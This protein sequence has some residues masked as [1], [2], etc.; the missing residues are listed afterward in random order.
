MITFAGRVV[1]L[2][3]I[4]GHLRD[5]HVMWRQVQEVAGLYRV[6]LGRD[7]YYLKY[8]RTT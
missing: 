7:F 2:L 3:A 1:L 8:Y 4:E 5:N 6:G